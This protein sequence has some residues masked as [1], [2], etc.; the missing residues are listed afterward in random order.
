MDD[1][2]TI[3][4]EPDSRLKHVFSTKFDNLGFFGYSLH[5]NII[6]YMYLRLQTRIV[7]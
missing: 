6:K 7:T 3:Y 2:R 4:E 1:R 5:D